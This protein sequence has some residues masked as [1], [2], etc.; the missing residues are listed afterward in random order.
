MGLLAFHRISGSCKRL[1]WELGTVQPIFRFAPAGVGKG[2]VLTNRGAVMSKARRRGFTLVEMLVVI[3]IIGI[4]VSLLLPAVQAAR[5]AARR[6]A[7]ANNLKQIALAAHNF[8]DARR[9]FPPGMNVSPNSRNPNP[10]WNMPPPIAGPYVGCL[11]Y[12]LPFMEQENVYQDIPRTLFDPN[13]TQGA[14]MY[15]YEPFDLN[16]AS[17]P[18]DKK[19]GT[20]KGYP[21]AANTQIETFLC[22]SDSQGGGVLVCDAFGFNGIY[23]TAGGYWIDWV[24]NIPS[25]GAELGRSNYAGVA[26]G[27]GKV[28]SNDPYHIDWV[29]YTGVYYRNSKTR[30]AHITDGLS[31]TLSLWRGVGLAASQRLPRVGAILAGLRRHGDVVGLVSCLRSQQRRLQ[32]LAVSEPTSGHRE[33]RLR[34]RLGPRDQSNDGLQ[35]LHLSVGHGGPTS[36]RL[37]RHRVYRSRACVCEHR[38]GVRPRSSGRDSIGGLLFLCFGSPVGS[39]DCLFP[40]SGVA[41]MR[42]AVNPGCCFALGGRPRCIAGIVQKAD[43][44]MH[45]MNLEPG[46]NDPVSPN[47][48]PVGHKQ[49]P[50]EPIGPAAPPPRWSDATR[51]WRRKLLSS[52]APGPVRT[53]FIVRRAGSAE[54][55]GQARRR[56]GRHAYVGRGQAAIARRTAG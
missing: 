37:R 28:E 6:M 53:Q 39:R 20:G 44:M 40:R 47:S 3:A 49:M 32:A 54:R 43:V 48:A 12:L 10:G 2:Q 16:D 51:K 35:H 41:S 9:I 30:P 26:G 46:Y 25:Y 27:Y 24:Y 14:W 22:P 33:L 42:Y 17:V 19:N 56:T 8:E 13:T 29:P 55:I 21:R 50:Q 45:G 15:S 38:I 7:C 4:L 1:R 18:S 23:P 34:R 52:D 11:A 5:E 31:E 36:H